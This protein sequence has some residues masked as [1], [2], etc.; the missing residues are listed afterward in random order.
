MT[1]RPIPKAWR[2]A[3]A[4]LLSAELSG[5]VSVST[6]RSKA[7]SPAAT[8][9]LDVGVYDT[10]SQAQAG[11]A[12]SRK[13]S[14]DLARLE[15]GSETRIQSFG[16]STWSVGELSP[17]KYRLHL[18]AAALGSAQGASPKIVE[19]DIRIRAGEIVRTDVVLKKFPTWTVV[20]ITAGVGVIAG[21]LISFNNSW[22]HWNTSGLHLRAKKAA[23]RRR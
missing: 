10:P 16:E 4:I 7:A 19:R 9:S 6:T 8:P 23:K 5:C 1:T 2:I 15:N 13:V 3:L 22:N 17:G 20:G 18:T 11:V 14:L 21:L 12:T